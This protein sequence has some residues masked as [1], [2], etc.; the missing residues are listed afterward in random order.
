MFGFVARARDADNA[1]GLKIVTMTSYL[2]PFDDRIAPS[3]FSPNFRLSVTGTPK[4]RAVVM[5]E[6]GEIGGGRLVRWG[7]QPYVGTVVF[8]FLLIIP[9]ML[10]LLA[11]CRDQKYTSAQ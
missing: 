10:C 5:G 11:L 4:R 1:F 9:A 3:G 7:I 6:D 2:V 8:G